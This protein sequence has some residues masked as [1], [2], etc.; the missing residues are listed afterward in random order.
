MGTRKI[1]WEVVIIITIKEVQKYQKQ[2]ISTLTNRYDSTFVKIHK[3]NMYIN[4]NSIKY[5]S[6]NK[7]KQYWLADS[8]YDTKMM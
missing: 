8:S 7:Y 4:T 2:S 5:K 3:K 6:S 1:M